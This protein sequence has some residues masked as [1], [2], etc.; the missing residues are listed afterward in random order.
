MAKNLCI[1]LLAIENGIISIGLRRISALV[2][3]KY[4][5]TTTYI[6]DL[7]AL[8]SKD[9]LKNWIYSNIPEKQKIPINEQ[10]VEELADSN[11]LGISCVSLYANQAKQLITRIKE[12]NPKTLVIWGGVHATLFPEDSI[13]YADIVCIGE[14]EKSFMALLNRIENGEEFSNLKGLWVKQN[15]HVQQNELMPLMRDEELGQRTDT[16]GIMFFLKIQKHVSKHGKVCLLC[17]L[18]DNV[19]QMFR[20]T[21]LE[22]LFNITLDMLAAENLLEEIRNR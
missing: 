19:M 2:K 18:Q 13:N 8:S 9:F 4:P 6:Y 11:V 1:K 16:S 21:K 15:G 7:G 10:L 22:R 17:G 5:E 14:G 20:I 12:K 3:T